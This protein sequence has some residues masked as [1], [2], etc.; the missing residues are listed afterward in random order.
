MDI[1]RDELNKCVKEALRG[2]VKDIEPFLSYLNTYI[3]TPGGKLD[4]SAL[5]NILRLRG[6]KEAIKS[7]VNLKKYLDEY[8]HKEDGSLDHKALGVVLKSSNKEA[9]EIIVPYLNRLN[10]YIFNKDGTLNGSAIDTILRSQCDKAIQTV[11]PYLDKYVKTDEG[12]INSNRIRRVINSNNSGAINKLYKENYLTAFVH[13]SDNPNEILD[14]WGK[15]LSVSKQILRVIRED[16][17]IPKN[18]QL[19]MPF[20]EDDFIPDDSIPLES[21]D[22]LIDPKAMD[23]I[24]NTQGTDVSK[25]SSSQAHRG[26]ALSHL[27]SDDLTLCDNLFSNSIFSPVQTQAN[28]V[29]FFPSSTRRLD[30]L[31]QLTSDDVTRVLG[32]PFS[33]ST[34][35]SNA[36]PMYRSN[37]EDEEKRIKLY[38]KP[39]S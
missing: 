14:E 34:I 18:S 35:F 26:N 10:E 1:P 36:D 29:N 15:R 32:N 21:I 16:L 17:N 38:S 7:I 27:T 23:K 28:A 25:P 20:T 5:T 9:V 4:R 3:L 13:E 24:F 31:P 19:F 22:S 12:N 2:K 30:D 33:G 6:N 11:L 8:V 37:Q 39:I